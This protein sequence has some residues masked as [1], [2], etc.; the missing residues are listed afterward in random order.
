MNVVA[1]EFYVCR[2]CGYKKPLGIVRVR[3]PKCG[4]SLTHA[5]VIVK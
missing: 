1:K 4:C 3:C 2:K 5:V